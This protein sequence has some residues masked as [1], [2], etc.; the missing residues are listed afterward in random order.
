M[1]TLTA[2]LIGVIAAFCFFVGVLIGVCGVGGILI[3]PFLVYVIGFDIH[4]VIPACMAGFVVS[5]IFAVYS[6]CKSRL[7]SLGQGSLPYYR[8]STRCI[9]GG[10]SLCWHCLH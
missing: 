9:F 1:I 7:N 5:M 8:S 3:I 2:F 6:Y 4:T 10:P